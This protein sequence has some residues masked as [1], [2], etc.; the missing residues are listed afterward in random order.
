MPAKGVV[1]AAKLAKLMNTAMGEGAEADNAIALVRKRV[2]ELGVDWHDIISG[3]RL[4]VSTRDTPPPFVQPI[5]LT[6][7]EAIKIVRESRISDRADLART[8]E[9]VRANGGT[10]AGNGLRLMHKWAREEMKR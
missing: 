3:A 7:D 5:E 6:L 10:V 8:L 1:D 4:R 9:R 2:R